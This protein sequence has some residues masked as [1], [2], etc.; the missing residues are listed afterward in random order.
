MKLER[1]LAIVMLLINRRH[2]NARS[3]RSTLKYSKER[4]TGIFAK[5]RL[6]I[7]RN[8]AVCAHIEY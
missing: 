1:L 7:C 2:I 4:Y 6:F 3:L 5:Q 8:K